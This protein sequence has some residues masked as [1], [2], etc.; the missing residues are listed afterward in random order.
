MKKLILSLSFILVTL[1]GQS[2]SSAENALF[3]IEAMGWSGTN[4]VVKLTNKVNCETTFRFNYTGGVKDTTLSANVTSMILLPN[5]S[6]NAVS[7]KVKRQ[8]GAVCLN[9]VSNDWTEISVL[10]IAL[11]IKFKSISVRRISSKSVRLDFESEEDNTIEK[12]HIKISTDGKLWK[13]VMV[14]F[15]NGVQGSKKYSVT[16]NL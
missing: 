10:Q 16:I 11:P 4:Y 14:I 5:M 1:F 15:P 9:G 13:D 8:S 7:I 12:Y 2:Q 6:T 3:R